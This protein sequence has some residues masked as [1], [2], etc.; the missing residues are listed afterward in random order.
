MR[1]GKFI[2][3]AA[4]LLTISA[5]LITQYSYA[6]TGIH[7]KSEDGSF[8][9]ARTM[10]FGADLVSFDLISVPR[11]YE[12]I[13]QTP[14]GKPGLKW[15][16]KYGY[17]GFNPFGMPLVADGI[18]EKGLAAGAFY[19]PGYAQYQEP[20]ESDNPTTIS[21]LDFVSWVLS[22]FSTVKEVSDAIAGIKV[23]G[24]VF[25]D[26]GIVP[27]LHFAIS[28]A[29]GDSIVFE[30]T[31]G[32]LYFYKNTLGV[33]TNS[34]TYDWHMT[35]V[36]NYIGLQAINRPSIEVD[37]QQ[38]TSFGQGSGALGL[39]GDFTPPSRFIR[40]AFFV[41][42]AYKGKTAL[43][44][45]NIAFKIL[46]QFDIPP[47]SVREQEGDKVVAEATQWTSAA[48]LKNRIY[49]FHTQF[50]RNVKAIDLKNINFT[51]SKISTINISKPGVYEDL[52]KSFN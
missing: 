19:F 12:Y 5:C 28:D 43:D 30:W 16:T 7:L 4:T 39:P 11:N 36:R 42:T 18:N 9:Y 40:A 41:N 20:T 1:L 32:R 48:D 26:W 25:K 47:G 49:Y 45:V 22:N 50:D 31:V 38:L 13:G 6:C 46:D 44:E 34:P 23:I 37:G 15:K 21:A 52:S 10:E 24:V 29:T 35:N 2:K 27:P 17:V 51:G 3:Q 8:V 33:I 14:N